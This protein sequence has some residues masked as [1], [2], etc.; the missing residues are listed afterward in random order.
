MQIQQ[1]ET[2]LKWTSPNQSPFYINNSGITIGYSAI[3]L[4]ID[5]CK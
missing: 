5:V 3:I 4:Y 1:K 2:F